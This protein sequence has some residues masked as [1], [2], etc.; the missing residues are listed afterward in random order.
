[1]KDNKKI[2]I[3]DQKLFNQIAVQYAKK[4]LYPVTRLVRKYQ[5]LTLFKLID[6]KLNVSLHG[7]I[8]ELGCGVGANSDYVKQF[9]KHYT[10]ID[11]SKELISLA[12]KNYSNNNINFICANIK[13]YTFN[14][15]NYN[16]IFGIGLLH[17]LPDINIVLRHLK[18]QT[19]KDATFGFLE[20]QSGNPLIQILRYIRKQT[21]SSYS[22]DQNIF[23]KNFITNVFKEE[24]FEIIS[25]QYQGY[26][27]PP[28]A[29]L[30]LKPVW[31][32]LPL[33][34]L[35]IFLDKLI[36]KYIN[37]F[38]SWNMIIIAKIK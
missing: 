34:K 7:N 10:G 23:S 25:I 13:D 12:I 21:D 15:Q 36:Q 18:N 4:D 31:I 8:L 29:Q 22:N 16:L 20:V 24:G 38:L 26:F 11:Y 35:A 33:A 17:H 2:E 9:Y 28:F 3:E 30:I 19:N 37:N 5:V 6:K 32:M 14:N 27:T 1:M